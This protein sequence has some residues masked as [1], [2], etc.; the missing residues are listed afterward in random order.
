MP[1]MPSLPSP[2]LLARLEHLGL[3]SPQEVG[4]VRRRVRR[5]A[6]KLPWFDSIWIDALRQAGLVTPYQANELTAQRGD[7]LQ[8]GPYV[9]ERPLDQAHY[10]RA[11]AAREI[12]SRRLVRLLRAPLARGEVE[13]AGKSLGKLLSHS[14]HLASPVLPAVFDFGIDEH[15][16]PS[17]VSP[18]RVWVVSDAVPGISAAGW[19]VASGR[20][21]PEVVWEIAR[22]M[23]AALAE[24]EHLELVHADLTPAGLIIDPQGQVRLPHPGVRAVLRP[25]EGYGLTELVPAAYDNLAPERIAA[26]T[27]PTVAS[28]LYACGCVWWQLLTG[29]GPHGGGDSLARLQAAHRGRFV[30]VCRLAPE[31]PPPLA[32]AVRSCLASKP[33]DRPDGFARLVEALGPSTE[34]GR[35]QLAECIA[36]TGRP[37]L[38]IRRPR[39]RTNWSRPR[40]NSPRTTL[41][42]TTSATGRWPYGIATAACLLALA[43][44]V[45]PL[46]RGGPPVPLANIDANTGANSDAGQ[47]LVATDADG[48]ATR[49]TADVDVPL[50]PA[51]GDDARL[52]AADPQAIASE[53]VLLLSGDRPVAASELNLRAGLTVRGLNHARVRIE[54]PPEGLHVAVDDVRFEN[55]DFVAAAEQAEPNAADASATWEEATAAL[56]VAQCRRVAFRGC[57]FQAAPASSRSGVRWQPPVAVEAEMASP[58]LLLLTDCLMGGLVAGIDLPEPPQGPLEFHDT[59]A[60]GP[61]PLVRLARSPRLEEPLSLRLSH[62]TLREAHALIEFNYERIHDEPGR[63]AVEA[64]NCVFAPTPQGAVIYCRGLPSPARLLH[65]VAWTGEGS[66]LAEEADFA[67]WHSDT[68]SPMTVDDVEFAIDGLAR[69]RIEFAGSSR[70]AEGSKIVDWSA[71][72][73]TRTPP[74]IRR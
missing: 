73:A 49:P 67:A 38:S 74:G 39:S 11:F 54:V 68:A 29:R 46:W 40:A 27:P 59:L 7:Q 32:D 9:I 14:A 64:K 35:K 63:V 5:L 50:E 33:G 2:D 21:P 31:T 20:F 28:D 30:D 65:R 23:A 13:R 34:T 69:S 62:V 18:S 1:P 12:S 45:W 66:L 55:I 42:R 4:T 58:H 37:S 52:A 72:L 44:I 16:E 26:G 15:N 48:P 60:L 10:A 70:E 8:A 53:K 6:G 51:Q 22:Q 25:E 71:P 3:A 43:A 61:G 41:P 56:V 47:N 24:L 19:M 36:E 17:Q 57:S